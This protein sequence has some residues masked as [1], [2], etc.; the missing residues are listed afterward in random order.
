MC[1]KGGKKT[2][3]HKKIHEER[4]PSFN[5]L[6]RCHRYNCLQRGRTH[7]Q[8]SGPRKWSHALGLLFSLCS[9]PI[10]A[11]TLTALNRKWLR[12]C[13]CCFYGNAI[14][15]VITN[16]WKGKTRSESRIRLP[17]SELNQFQSETWILFGLIWCRIQPASIK[18]TT[19]NLTDEIYS[20][21]FRLL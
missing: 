12:F 2:C 4:E 1:K 6:K 15:K 19:T 5:V 11:T 7:Q 10:R 9:I 14:S 17:E 13:I 3:R 21:L 18:I 16:K 20:D 8:Q